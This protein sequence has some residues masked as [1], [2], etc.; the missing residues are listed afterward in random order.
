MKKQKRYFYSVVEEMIM[1]PAYAGYRGGRVEIWDH[2]S[3]SPFA[4][5]EARFMIP[6]EFYEDFCKTF[7]WKTSELPIYIRWEKPEIGG[8]DG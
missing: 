1:N 7:D 4:A 2:K 3:D 5:H 6:E 8:S